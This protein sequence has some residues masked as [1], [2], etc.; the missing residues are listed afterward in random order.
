MCRCS[1]YLCLYVYTCMYAWVR[2]CVTAFRTRS[3]DPNLVTG[4]PDSCHCGP[5]AQ[6]IQR[7]IHGMIRR[8]VP[9]RAVKTKRQFGSET[10]SF[11]VSV[12]SCVIF[13]FTVIVFYSYHFMWLYIIFYHLTCCITSCE[14]IDCSPY[15]C[16]WYE[17]A[18]VSFHVLVND[19]YWLRPRLI[20]CRPDLTL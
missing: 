7:P 11:H 12:C 20:Y 3:C 13:F 14:I 19:R 8:S 17:L 2:L 16:S 15:L 10:A 4:D 1:M 5:D 6:V 9:V 18:S